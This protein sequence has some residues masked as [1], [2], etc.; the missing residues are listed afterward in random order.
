MKKINVFFIASLALFLTQVC[1][2]EATSTATPLLSNQEYRV[3]SGDIETF[4]NLDPVII[5]GSAG[6]DET[7]DMKLGANY[8]FTD[9]LAPGL[10]VDLRTGDGT[11]IK[12]LPNVKAYYPLDSRFLPY[13][14]VGF[15]YEHAVGDDFA[16]FVIGPGVNYLLSNSV[17]IGMQFRYDLGAGSETLHEFQ[18]PIQFAVYFKY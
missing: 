14:Q 8:F 17:A 12:L 15:G 9:I 6:H 10:E 16:A 18:F 1:H 2:A 5:R 11:D 3:G 13:L 7:F 4:V